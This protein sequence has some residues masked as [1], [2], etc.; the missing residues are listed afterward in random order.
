MSA[1]LN[2]NEAIKK[3]FRTSPLFGEGA[4]VL[5]FSFRRSM[6]IRQNSFCC[7]PTC[8]ANIRTFITEFERGMNEEDYNDPRFSFRVAFVR[9]LVNGKAS[10][11]RLVEFVPAST[12]ADEMNRV[13]VKETEKT[14]Y[15]PEK[16]VDMMKA[17]G[18]KG[19]HDASVC[20][21]L[22]VAQR[23]AA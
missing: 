18:Y 8:S 5:A 22:A 13:Y 11:D 19:L 17:E 12:T 9:K 3:H 15:R 23:Q 4:S 20:G 7:D 6:K 14:K 10:A 1:A 16:I 2:F 21:A